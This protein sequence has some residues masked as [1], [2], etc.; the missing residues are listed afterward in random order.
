ML[1]EVEELDLVLAHY[2]ITWGLKV[3]GNSVSAPWAEWGLKEVVRSEED[4]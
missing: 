1:D 3:Y 2:A 4:D